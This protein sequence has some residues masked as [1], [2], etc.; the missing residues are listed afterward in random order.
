MDTLA[1]HRDA[2]FAA[3]CI[4]RG[5]RLIYL[6]PYSPDL[7]PIER[8]LQSQELYRE[9]GSRLR[10]PRFAH[11]HPHQIQE[12]L[13]TRSATTLLAALN[14]SIDKNN[15]ATM[16]AQPAPAASASEDMSL[17]TWHSDRK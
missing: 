12:N 9:P 16:G 4:E 6:P 1:A 15:F 5:V 7:N 13:E 3:A 2:R 14:S 8:R 11:P 17:A 10:V